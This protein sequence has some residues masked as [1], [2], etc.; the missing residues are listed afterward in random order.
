M[1]KGKQ[2]D[3]D[4][5]GAVKEQP[6]EDVKSTDVQAATVNGFKDLDNKTLIGIAEN[7]VVRDGTRI[8]ALRELHGRPGCQYNGLE[9]LTMT[10]L[11]AIVKMD[12]VPDDLRAAAADALAMPRPVDKTK[13]LDE[14]DKS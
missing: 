12:K 10:F 14:S 4:A 9:R 7:S 13:T 8:A 6:S 5:K 2:A 3:A 11:Q 1:E